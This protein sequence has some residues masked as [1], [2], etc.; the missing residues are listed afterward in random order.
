MPVKRNGCF[1]S[2]TTNQG[3][4][5]VFSKGKA[6]VVAL[7][8]AGF[9]SAGWSTDRIVLAGGSIQAAIN[10]AV[11]GDRI[12]IHAGTYAQTV[13]V[14]NKNTITIQPFGDGSVYLSPSNAHVITLINNA[15]HCTINQMVIYASGTGV[16]GIC[17]NPGCNNTSINNCYIYGD[18]ALN[19]NAGIQ[20][21]STV[22]H[23]ML[24]TVLIGNFKYGIYSWDLA[25]LSM[26]YCTIQNVKYFTLYAQANTSHGSN[27]C[28][29]LY[30]NR[31]FCAPGSAGGTYDVY[32]NISNNPAPGGWYNYISGNRFEG[33]AT[34][35]PN[36]LLYTYASSTAKVTNNISGNTFN[37]CRN[38]AWNSMAGLTNV[39]QGGNIFST[40]PVCVA[41]GN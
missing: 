18:A 1:V 29:G 13:T 37:Y 6:F 25:D 22:E 11:S 38:K 9:F 23:L 5:M 2:Y 16:N 39:N 41:G 36:F 14:N 26:S 31:F 27:A 8:V 19:C 4:F 24:N 28:Y 17:V 35:M 32:L 20:E 10:A 30:T 12:L 33:Q 15:H 34:N 3:G 7:T 40:N 21:Y